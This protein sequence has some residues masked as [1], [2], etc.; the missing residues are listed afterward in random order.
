VVKINI[1][2]SPSRNSNTP[3]PKK[4]PISKFKGK[5]FNKKE[6]DIRDVLK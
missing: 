4:R 5:A 2:T 3:N 6:D 1:I